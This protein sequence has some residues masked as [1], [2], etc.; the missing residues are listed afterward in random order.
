MTVAVVGGGVVGMLSAYL[1]AKHGLDVV[2]LERQGMG[3]ESSWPRG[4]I[5]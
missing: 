1:L 3:S 5:V 2:V 4:G